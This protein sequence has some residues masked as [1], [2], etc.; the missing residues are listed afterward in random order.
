M[1][2][3]DLQ[4][5]CLK[6]GLVMSRRYTSFECGYVYPVYS[7]PSISLSWDNPLGEFTVLEL[8]GSDP[9]D[10]EAQVV[11]WSL[12]ASFGGRV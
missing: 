12:K 1:T 6:Y 9:G 5:L 4:P 3:E 8:S 10:V 2:P 7:I 11:E